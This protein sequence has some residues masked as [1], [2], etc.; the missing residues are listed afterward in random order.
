MDLPV[1]L[2]HIVRRAWH[3]K[4]ARNSI[5]RW[6]AICDK[7]NWKYNAD[8]VELFAGVFGASWYFTR[9]VFVYGEKALAIAGKGVRRNS[10]GII[11]WDPLPLH[12]QVMILK[13]T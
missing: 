4:A 10:A 3:E 13:T 5:E 12:P 6:I 11:L 9:F 8:T 2:D 7:E 1:N